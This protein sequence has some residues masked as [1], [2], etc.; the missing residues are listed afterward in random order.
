MIA[1]KAKTSDGKS[2]R[3]FL[4]I[5]ESEHGKDTY[6]LV[7]CVQDGFGYRWDG[8]PFYTG[9]VLLPFK[10]GIEDLEEGDRISVREPKGRID[11]FHDMTYVTTLGITMESDV[12]S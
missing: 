9:R 3:M 6:D 8:H 4:K 2:Y 10:K 7:G 11:I 12:T 5:V 1:I